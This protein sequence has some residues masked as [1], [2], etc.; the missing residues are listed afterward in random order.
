MGI[1]QYSTQPGLGNIKV[2]PIVD[3]II[4]VQITCANNPTVYSPSQPNY[5]TSHTKSVGTI[6]W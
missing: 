3:C 6:G 4:F 5:M 2:F 1:F